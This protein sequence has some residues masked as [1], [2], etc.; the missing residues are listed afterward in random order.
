MNNNLLEHTYYVIETYQSVQGEQ[1]T[2]NKLIEPFFN[3]LG[4]DI[5]CI[6]DIRTEM[7][8]DIGIKNEKVDYILC[9]NGEPKILVEAKDWKVKLSEKNINQLYRYFAASNCKMAILTNGL[10]YWFFSD[11]EKDNIMDSRPFYKLNILSIHESDNQIFN[12]ISKTQQCFYPIEKYLIEK[13]SKSLY[14]NK[15]KLA[16]LIAISYFHDLSLKDAVYNGIK[17]FNF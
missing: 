6:D 17:N 2:K 9:F 1:E 3:Q 5:D 16:E 15:D 10:E 4:Y 7:R 13:K 8:C 12:A 14:C 11:F